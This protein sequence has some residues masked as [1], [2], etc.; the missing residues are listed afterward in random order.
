MVLAVARPQPLPLLAQGWPPHVK[1][2]GGRDPPG[3]LVD[4]PPVQLDILRSLSLLVP[5]LEGGGAHQA[6]GV[7]EESPAVEINQTFHFLYSAGRTE[8]SSRTEWLSAHL[9]TPQVW[10]VCSIPT[11][12]SSSLAGLT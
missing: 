6:R 12:S 7:L 5:Q 8:D 4:G 1:R 3:V 11:S 9:T 2:F 10:R